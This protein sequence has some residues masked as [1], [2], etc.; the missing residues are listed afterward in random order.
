[1]NDVSNGPYRQLALGY[2]PR[3]AKPPNTLLTLSDK[4][5]DVKGFAL[6]QDDGNV[7]NVD[8]LFVKKQSRGRGQ[9]LMQEAVSIAQGKGI[10]RVELWSLPGAVRFYEGI[11]FEPVNPPMRNGG[12]MFRDL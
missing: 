6:L 3:A 5:D 1:M 11:G 10:Q 8:R 4:N 7:L 2:L 9:R 12:P